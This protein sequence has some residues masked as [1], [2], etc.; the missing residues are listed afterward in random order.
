MFQVT[1]GQNKAFKQC[2]GNWR[3]RRIYRNRGRRTMDFERTLNPPLRKG[4]SKP[5][6][7]PN[8][9]PHFRTM[10]NIGVIMVLHKSEVGL[11]ATN[12]AQPIGMFVGNCH[13]IGLK[14]TKSP[15]FHWSKCTTFGRLRLKRRCASFHIFFETANGVWAA[16]WFSMWAHNRVHW[17]DRS[18]WSICHKAGAIAKSG[19]GVAS[20]ENQTNEICKAWWCVQQWE[21]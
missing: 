3:W 7:T 5:S 4:R 14:V 15:L 13:E 11:K 2:K 20:G 16:A 19:Q 6:G 10:H 21:D 9:T 18:E 8:G 12:L 17:S 1:K